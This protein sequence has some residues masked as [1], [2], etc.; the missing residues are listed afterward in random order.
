MPHLKMFALIKFATGDALRSVFATLMLLASADAYAQMPPNGHLP[1]CGPTEI[2][3]KACLS[4]VTAPDGSRIC[5]PDGMKTICLPDVTIPGESQVNDVYQC[6]RDARTCV[7]TTP[8][9]VVNG[10]SVTLAMAGGC[11]QWKRDYTCSTS[12]RQNTCGPFEQ[13]SAC[14][15][16]GRQCL[17]Q[18]GVFG[19]SEW[20]VEYRC[21]TKPGES[22]QVEYCGDRDICI[23][24]VC[25]DTGYPPDED[26]AKVITDMEAGRQ[27][28]VYSS[29]GLDIFKGQASY[30]RSKR[31]AGLKNC[32]SSEG[33]GQSNNSVMGEAISGAAGFA[34][35]AGSKYV[36]D[37]LYGD[38]VNWMSSGWS[39]AVGGNLPGG[40]GLLD[41]IGSPGFG[42]YGFSIGGTGSF[43]G[44]AGYSLGTAGGFPVYFNPYAF[45]FAIAVQVVMSAMT[46]DEEEAMLAMKRGANLCTD[47]IDDWCTKKILGVCITRKRSY[48]CYNSKLA[49]IINVQGRAQLGMGWGDTQSPTCNGFSAAQ[50][51]QIDFTEIDFSEFIGDVMGA[52][53][54]SHLA[55]DLLKMQGPSS[56]DDLKNSTLETSCKRTF[57][58]LGGDL[59][60]MPAECA[61]FI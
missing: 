12:E 10:V 56:G 23:G 50:L 13:D 36:F 31:G 27:I 35:R 34:A 26:F 60:K 28:G 53:D 11:W 55:E 3:D 33:G 38:T 47:A 41:S 44:T 61:E 32:C 24:G 42:M 8:V 45:A 5:A 59:K 9:K 49:K 30:C 40:Q 6:R 4:F 37:T 43:L 51:K 21:I 29:D 17:S 46:C 15:A 14:S 1:P 20:K 18:A 39:A 48:C 58:A 2:T 19:C 57:E 54:T 52:I 22:Y 25:W 7:D 16:Y